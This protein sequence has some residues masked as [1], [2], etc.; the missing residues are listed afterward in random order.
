MDKRQ[1]N[2]RSFADIPE[3]EH[4]EISRKGGIASGEAR[5]ERATLR[6][7]LEQLL[8]EKNAKMGKTYRELTTLGLIKGAI[9]GKAE[10]YKVIATMMGELDQ[11]DDVNTREVVINVVDNSQL[12]GVLYEDND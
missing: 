10:N 6:K 8:D 11:K 1:E 12:E 2:L 5:K 7:A 3:E 9:D 4:K